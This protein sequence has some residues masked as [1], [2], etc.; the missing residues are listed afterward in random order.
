LD[1]T[2][3]P[4]IAVYFSASSALENEGNIAEIKNKELCIWAVDRKEMENMKYVGLNQEGTVKTYTEF[5]EPSGL[6]NPNAAAQES[7]FSICRYSDAAAVNELPVGMDEIPAYSNAIRKIKISHRY[8][9][10][11][12]KTLS[13]NF[14][15]TAKKIFPSHEGF[16]RHIN[17]SMLY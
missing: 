10:E 14:G 7:V 11:I 9:A 2:R 1:W 3:Q 4:L 12:L 5:F 17:E 16:V 15:I 13:V 8:A 6:S